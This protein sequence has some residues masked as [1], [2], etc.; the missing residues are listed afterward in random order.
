[1]EVLRNYI[2]GEWVSGTTTIENINPSDSRDVINLCTQGKAK[3]V[4]AAVNA[5][6]TAFTTWRNA[7]PQVRHDLLDSIGNALLRRKDT[8]GEMLSREEGKTLAEGVGE[9]V[10]AGQLFKFFAGEALRI[11]GEKVDSVRPGV[12]VDIVR[13]PIGVVGVITPWNFPIA[14]PAWK[15]APALAY[16][17]CVIFKPAYSTPGMACVIASLFEEFGGPSGVL[18]LVMGSGSEVGGAMVS[19]PDIAAISFTGSVGVGSGIAA[20]C[21]AS[22][23]KVQLEM[24][25]KN[26]MIVME[27]AD[28]SVAVSAC[29]NGAFFSTGQRCTAS[30]RFIVHED[31]HD[32]FV[33]ATKQAME[34]LKVGNALSPDTDIGPVIDEKQLASNLRYVELAKAEGADVHGGQRLHLDMPGCYQAPALFVNTDNNMRINQEEIF[35]PCASVIKCKGFEEAIAIANDTIFGLSAGICTTS[36][37]Y[38]REF[39]RRADAGVLMVNLPTAGLDY[40]VPF[41][42]R[43][44][45]SYGPKEQG[46]YA[47]EFY[48]MVKTV[49]INA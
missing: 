41:G 35:G 5:A 30:S 13:E 44:Q 7:S 46:K 1:M 11:Y 48:T 12:D 22:Q 20:T 34:K 3:D 4:D 17:N 26:P 37:K 33:K 42:G 10:R 21:G 43:K 39:R 8:V 31:I 40:H 47:V 49:Y 23:K 25:G 29:V 2:G 38:S 14:I 27:D 16:G 9:T 45:S 28:L 18:N 15:I 36:L 32:D 19:H 6:R 24:G